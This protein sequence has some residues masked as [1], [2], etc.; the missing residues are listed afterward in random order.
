MKMSAAYRSMAKRHDS[1]GPGHRFWALRQYHAG[2][3]AGRVCVNG[4]AAPIRL[5]GCAVVISRSDSANSHCIRP[6][7]TGNRQRFLLRDTK[8]PHPD[9]EAVR[10]QILPGDQFTRSV[11]DGADPSARILA[12]IHLLPGRSHRRMLV[13][14]QFPAI[15]PLRIG[16]TDQSRIGLAIRARDVRPVA[17]DDAIFGCLQD[18]PVR[19]FQIPLSI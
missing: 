5:L 7:H 18:M 2:S 13:K 12:W 1:Q 15:R 4:I 10:R 14:H 8:S 16:R 6:V 3:L 17:D 11:V 9:S 19:H